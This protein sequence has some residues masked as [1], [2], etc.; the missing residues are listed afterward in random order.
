MTFMMN[1][2]EFSKWF[3]DHKFTHL[4]FKE[5]RLHKGSVIIAC[6]GMRCLALGA[7]IKVA[8]VELMATRKKWAEGAFNAIAKA[9]ID[10]GTM[11]N[12]LV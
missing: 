1:T 6:G 7:P 8:C 4:Y 5:L 2:G 3:D 9:P 11:Y 10:G 12:A